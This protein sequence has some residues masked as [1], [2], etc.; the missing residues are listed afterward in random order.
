MVFS[1]IQPIQAT[2]NGSTNAGRRS[3]ADTKRKAGTAGTITVMVKWLVFM[4]PNHYTHC[5]FNISYKKGIQK[6]IIHPKNIHHVNHDFPINFTKID[7][8][9]M[10]P[11]FGR[12]ML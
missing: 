9:M 2:P 1:G 11:L 5:V 7:G 12:E 10:F 4:I 8:L 3:H 6:W